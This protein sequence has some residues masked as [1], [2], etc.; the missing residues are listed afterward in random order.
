[1]EVAH[2]GESMAGARWPAIDHHGS[3]YFTSAEAAQVAGGDSRGQPA[4]A[5]VTARGRTRT[6]AEPRHVVPR[7]AGQ[8][9]SLA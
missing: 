9:L 7:R 3:R 4:A 1:M 6:R 5:Y 2:C 8:G